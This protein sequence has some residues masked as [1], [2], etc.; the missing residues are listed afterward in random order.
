MRFSRLDF[1]I[2]AGG[3]QP[4]KLQFEAS[5]WLM[6]DSNDRFVDGQRVRTFLIEKSLYSFELS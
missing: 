5:W 2:C 1:E 3:K 6:I 4:L